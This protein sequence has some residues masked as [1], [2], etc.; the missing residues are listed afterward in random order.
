MGTQPDLFDDDYA[1]P[2]K[3]R[4]G[5]LSFQP[6]PQAVDAGAHP[7]PD[8]WVPDEIP[9]LR[10]ETRIVLNC[11]TNGLKWWRED[12]PIGWSY[13]FPESG[14]CGYLPIRHVEGNLPVE[15]VHA[16]LRDLRGLHVENHNLKFDLHHARAD[17]VDLI[18]GTGNTFGDTMHVAALLDDNRRRFRLDELSKDILGWDVRDPNVDPL[19]PLPKGVESEA[20]WWQLPSWAVKPYATRNV[21]Q[22]RRLLDVQLPQIADED[23]DEVLALE[24]DVI[25]VVVEIEKN[26]VH[27]DLPLLDRWR[28]EAR[29]ALED[30]LLTVRRATGVNIE[31]F[32]SPKALEAVFR[33]QRLPL[34]YTDTGRP[35]F[36]A[37]VL[38]AHRNNDCVRAITEGG[39]LADLLSKYLD[40][41]W[42]TVRQSDGWLRHNL[43]Q[44]K[45]IRDTAGGDAVGTISGRFSAAGDRLSAAMR[46]DQLGTGGY[47]PQQAVAV[48]KQLERG[49]CPDYVIR[50]L[51][52]L[53]FAADMMQVEYRLFAHYA[54]MA[55]AYHERPK[56]HLDAK[57]KR[58]W[59]AGPLADFHAVVAE[60]LHRVNPNLNRKLVKNINFA[61]IYGAGLIKFALML[62]QIT[63]EQFKALNARRT[64][65][66]RTVWRDPL[67]AEADALNRAYLDMFPAVGPLL[68]T[69]ALRAQPECLSTRCKCRELG[70]EHRG[71]VR[72]FLGRR[73]RPE[74][75]YHSA[76]N[77]II[78]GGAA[79]YN[80]RVLVEVYKARARLGLTLQL[81]M[82]DEIAGTLA[83][84]R[85]VG[86]VKRVLNRQYYAFRAPILWETKTGENWAAC[87]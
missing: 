27:L 53:N 11:E 81:T 31:S 84:P 57:G 62:G 3:K 70:V 36:T 17:G 35:S 75:R 8:A 54:N 80:K 67:L 45:A 29:T 42:A 47:N 79:T 5:A 66:D 15:R 7:K 26:G 73:A 69:A 50:K 52:K 86:N 19:G 48:E 68:E 78:Q 34:S 44:L 74:G 38:H 25:P 43:H 72:D 39:Q 22:V 65:R 1:R 40:K 18:E 87:K 14:R 82:H 49:F 16:W 55:G 51:F 60:L 41:Y 13:L 21:E 6:P 32:D 63:E 59:T 24:Q 4:A 77:R 85:T 10:G 46:P 2:A 30:R 64:Q 76:L 33:S 58:V 61:K 56:H 28:K 83:D 23:L 12:R 37:A 9:A 71:Y 20:D